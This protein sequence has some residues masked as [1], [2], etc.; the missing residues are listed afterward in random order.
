M[1]TAQDVNHRPARQQTNLPPNPTI[2]ILPKNPVSAVIPL[3]GRY[4]GRWGEYQPPQPGNTHSL[5]PAINTLANHASC[6]HS[7]M[8]LID[9]WAMA[10]KGGGDLE[11]F[12]DLPAWRSHAASRLGRGEAGGSNTPGPSPPVVPAMRER[13]KAAFTACYQAVQGLLAEDRRQRCKLFKELPN[14]KLY[15]DYYNLIQKPIAMSHMRKRMSSG[16]YKT[17]AAYR[18]D[19][20]LMFNNTHMYKMEDSLVY[21][22]ADAMQKVLEAVFNWETAGTDMPGTDPVNPGNTSLLSA[23]D[24]DEPAPRPPGHSKPVSRKTSVSDEG[25]LSS[26]DDD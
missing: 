5:C 15:P 8:A 25:Y 23:A 7:S 20:R 6:P 14:C 12:D 13:M 10:L 16:Y 2:Y 4:G 24:G 19:W 22:N 11:D 1:T 21:Q 26:N 3:T 18:D 9:M 17:V